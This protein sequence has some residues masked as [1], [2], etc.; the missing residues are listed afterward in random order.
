MKVRLQCDR[1]QTV[2]VMEDDEPDAAD[3]FARYM[4]R[5]GC[6]SCGGHTFSPICG[7][8][9]ET[10]T[11]GAH[12]SDTYGAQ[13]LFFRYATELSGWDDPMVGAVTPDLGE[14]FRFCDED[15]HVLVHW[16]RWLRIG[17]A[18]GQDTITMDPERA[19]ALLEAMI[20]SEMVTDPALARMMRRAFHEGFGAR[21]PDQL[22]LFPKEEDV[23]APTEGR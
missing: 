9:D 1:C 16:A 19:E 22:D 5:E 8:D 3:S 14:F 21:D 17:H 20:A 15:L 2:Y 18:C 12:W 6:D 23:D 7:G 10:C 11:C 4:A 13:H